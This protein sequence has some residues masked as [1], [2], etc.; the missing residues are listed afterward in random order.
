MPVLGVLRWKEKK[1]QLSFNRNNFQNVLKGLENLSNNTWLTDLQK[2]PPTV[3]V[4]IIFIVPYD[5]Q[6]CLTVCRW[7]MTHWF[8][9]AWAWKYCKKY[10]WI[11]VL[12]L[13]WSLYSC[14]WTLCLKNLWQWVLLE[15][16]Q[17]FQTLAYLKFHKQDSL[18]YSSF[19]LPCF[20]KEK[21]E[22][23]CS[24]MENIHKAIDPFL[25]HQ[26]AVTCY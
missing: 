24:R 5:F 26:R 17:N 13:I 11:S 3:V 8:L 2:N 1:L 4:I 20:L 10:L 14:F 19:C 15:N 18:A 21:G 9:K 16:I 25:F 23:C 6:V 12:I 7:F 22:L